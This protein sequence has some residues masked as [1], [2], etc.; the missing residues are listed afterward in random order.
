MGVRLANGGLDLRFQKNAVAIGIDRTR[1]GREE[2]WDSLGFRR[3]Q[4]PGQLLPE[5]HSRVP[6]TVLDFGTADSADD[7]TV[8][9]GSTQFGGSVSLAIAGF[10]TLSGNSWLRTGE[11]WFHNED[12]AGGYQ[13]ECIP[14]QQSGQRA[15]QR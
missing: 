11:S 2:R 3:S 9:P 10:T 14:W 12:Q 15:D 1:S 4:R 8:L 7:L 5:E 6:E 13:C